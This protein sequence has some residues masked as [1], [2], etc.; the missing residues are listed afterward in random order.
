M[1]NQII[2]KEDLLYMKIRWKWKIKP[3]QVNVTNYLKIKFTKQ[4]LGRHLAKITTSIKWWMSKIWNYQWRRKLFKSDWK[5]LHQTKKRQNA[6]YKLKSDY[7]ICGKKLFQKL[8]SKPSFERFATLWH[9]VTQSSARL[10]PHKLPTLD[11]RVRHC[12]RARRHRRR[13]AV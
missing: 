11:H 2:K 8:Q 9:E 6:A 7:T 4:A 5:S 3:I 13:E 10:A 1:L 12:G